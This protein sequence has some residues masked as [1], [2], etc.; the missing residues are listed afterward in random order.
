MNTS[1]NPQQNWA[2][3]TLA[4]PLTLLLPHFISVSYLSTSGVVDLCAITG[5]HGLQFVPEHNAWAAQSR[6]SEHITHILL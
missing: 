6:L 1:I 3:Q 5:C 4:F 2:L